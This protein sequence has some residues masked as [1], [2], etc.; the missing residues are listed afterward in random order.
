MSFWVLSRVLGIPVRNPTPRELVM[1]G[2][3]LAKVFGGDHECSDD[4]LVHTE[5]SCPE[6]LVASGL[7]REGD[8]RVCGPA[9]PGAGH[10][11]HGCRCTSG[12][13]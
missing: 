7:G 11:R 13:V 3:E 5:T 6:V 2:P 4:D 1:D 8:D 12:R 10:P 9:R